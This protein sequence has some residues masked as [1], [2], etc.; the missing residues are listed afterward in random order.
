[1]LL[2]AAI[3]VIAERGEGFSVS[4]VS[5]R[6]GVSNGTFY[7]YFEDRD[8]LVEAVVPEVLAAFAAES[9]DRVD[10]ADPAQRFATITALALRRAAVRP[11]QLR[12]V[13][14]LDAVQRA[15]LHGGIVDHLRA[16]LAEGVVTGRFEVDAEEPAVDVVVGAILLACRHLVDR[17]LDD[18]YV[19]GV[20]TQLLRSLGL[21]NDEAKELAG[22]GVAGAAELDENA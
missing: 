3:D 11:D 13:L 7:N 17:G 9:A 12:V 14:R 21:P 22:L 10:V 6:A 18:G 19:A 5:T 4:D 8:A 20:V 1:M 2:D 15:L 16:D